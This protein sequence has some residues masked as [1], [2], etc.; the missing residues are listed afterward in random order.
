MSRIKALLIGAALLILAGGAAAYNFFIGFPRTFEG[1][2]VHRVTV[3]AQ[4]SHLHPEMTYYAYTGA[5][6]NEVRHGAFQRFDNGH[7]VQEETYRNGKLDG[8]ITYRNLFDEKTQE[9]YYRD[10]T[11][12]GWAFYKQ[13]KLINMRQEVM[14]DGRTVAVKI[15]DH[16]RY[17]LQFKC[18]ELINA[19]IDPASGEISSLAN[20]THHACV[21]P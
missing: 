10:G 13:G 18:G 14:Q 19:S 17:S 12:Y 4:G 7:L 2:R 21:G 11:P 15:F 5:G 1:K 8:V 20:A 16:D 3:W 6:G 9:V